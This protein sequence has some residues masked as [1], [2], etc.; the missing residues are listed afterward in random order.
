MIAQ[1]V[2]DAVIDLAIPVA[3]AYQDVIG[4]LELDVL[5]EPSI[6][7]T[8]ALYVVTSEI[9]MMRNFVNPI[10]NLISSLRDHKSAAFIAEVGGRGDIKKAP[11]GVKISPMVSEFLSK[12]MRIF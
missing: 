10:V 3:T 9:T 8:T 5:T 1:A 2:I 11:T 6:K 12:D 4:E 7:H